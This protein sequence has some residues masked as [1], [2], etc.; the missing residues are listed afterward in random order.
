M[1]KNKQHSNN[2]TSNSCTRPN[3]NNSRS[4][5]HQ[6]K[7]SPKR[8]NKRSKPRRILRQRLHTNRHSPKRWNP[9][10]RRHR[11][12]NSIHQKHRQRTRN[13][14]HDHKQLEPNQRHLITNPNM[15]PTKHSPKRRSINPSNT[16]I[17]S[18]IKHRQPNNLQLR[19]NTHRHPIIIHQESL[20]SKY[21]EVCLQNPTPLLP[22]PCMVFR[23][24]FIENQP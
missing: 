11:H 16:N 18:S 10:P 7:R 4:P 15:E 2:R 20:N 1:K 14:N 24:A 6:P 21:F 22:S 13:T 3:T 12:T 19:R 9:Q 17:N 8:N 5:Q 23:V